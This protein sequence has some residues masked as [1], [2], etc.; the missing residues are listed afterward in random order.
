[1]R[2]VKSKTQSHDPIPNASQVFVRFAFFAEFCDLKL[3][4]SAHIDAEL[5]LLLLHA[6]VFALNYDLF[7]TSE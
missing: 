3:G 1:M 6:L 4:L 7:L 2:Q 5:L